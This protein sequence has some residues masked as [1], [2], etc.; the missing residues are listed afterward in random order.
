MQEIQIPNRGSN[1]RILGQSLTDHC[2]DDV[3]MGM[4][5]RKANDGLI[6]FVGS[7]GEI[8]SLID[9][10]LHDPLVIGI[11]FDRPEIR[12]RP[13]KETSQPRSVAAFCPAAKL[14]VVSVLCEVGD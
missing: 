12:R 3:V 11:P 9:A 5:R 8:E 14:L 1:K 2:N 7:S 13:D 4:C 6:L 10:P